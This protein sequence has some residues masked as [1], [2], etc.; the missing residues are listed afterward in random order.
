MNPCVRANILINQTRNLLAFDESNAQHLML[1][2]FRTYPSRFR[3]AV[4][5]DLLE[6]PGQLD[7]D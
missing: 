1:N 5:R 7:R 4:P 6:L 2:A 3:L